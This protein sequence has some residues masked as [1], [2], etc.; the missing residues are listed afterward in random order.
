M[1]VCRRLE[2]QFV[3]SQ[4][5]ETPQQ[6]KFLHEACL[7]QCVVQTDPLRALNIP[8]TH[9]H[10]HTFTAVMCYFR[11]IKHIHTETQ[12][13]VFSSLFTLSCVVGQL[14]TA[15]APHDS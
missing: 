6:I 2:D 1:F 15:E 14:A 8:H 12:Q 13:C 11:S 4:R 9:I 5:A 10:T 7:R 3:V